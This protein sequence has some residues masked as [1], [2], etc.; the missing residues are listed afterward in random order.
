MFIELYHKDFSFRVY[1]NKFSDQNYSDCEVQ[2]VLMI[3]MS[4]YPYVLSSVHTC[5]EIAF[6]NI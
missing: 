2:F 1:Q 4:R 5:R 3:D 6:G